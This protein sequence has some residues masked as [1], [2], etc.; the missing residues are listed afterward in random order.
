MVDS[1]RDEPEVQQTLDLAELAR[2]HRGETSSELCQRT[3]ENLRAEYLAVLREPI[4][5][6]LQKLVEDMRAAETEHAM[7]G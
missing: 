6:R 7:P 4:P 5:E 1:L 2:I 3:L